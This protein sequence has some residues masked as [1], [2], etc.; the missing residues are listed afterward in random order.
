MSSSDTLVSYDEGPHT[1]RRHKSTACI[2][3]RRQPKSPVLYHA[4]PN[5]YPAAPRPQPQAA[6][7]SNPSKRGSFVAPSV[8]EA[9]QDTQFKY[10]GSAEK[11]GWAPGI[12]PIFLVW[13]PESFGSRSNFEFFESGREYTMG[14]SPNCDFFVKNAE[15]DSAISAEHLRIKVL[16]VSGLLLMEDALGHWTGE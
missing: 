9:Q 6:V 7:V 13:F 3:N 1:L 14:R 10:I 4:H 15:K 16:D 12:V 8:C 11:R 2:A 5:A